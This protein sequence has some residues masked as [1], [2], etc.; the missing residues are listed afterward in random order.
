MYVER[1]LSINNGWSI[2]TTQKNEE[3]EE[4]LSALEALNDTALKKGVAAA[5]SIR[6]KDQDREHDFLSVFMHSLYCSFL[7][8]GFGWIDKLPELSETLAPI[9]GR[10]FTK[11]GLLASVVGPKSLAGKDFLTS[12][13]LNNP[14]YYH[15]GLLDIS[16]IFIPTTKSIKHLLKLKAKKIH[17]EGLV[18]EDICRTEFEKFSSLNSKVPVVLAFF[19]PTKSEE[20]AVEEVILLGTGT[21]T[22]ERTIEFAPEYYQ[23]GVGLL[24][25]FGE[26]LRQK[27]PHT[28]AKV[29]IE[30]DGNTVRLHI[31]PPVGEIEIIEKQLQQFALVIS[32]QA[33][34]ET[35][36]E[37][38]MHIMQLESR[39]EIAKLEIKNA[40]DL[41]Q[42][43]DGIYSQQI[44]SLRQQVDSLTQQVASQVLQQGK[45]VN[46]TQPDSKSEPM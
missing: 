5:R 10:L 9:Y 40:H 46:L 32:N 26:V 42:L 25:Y 15:A 14:Y 37:N 21:P 38:R 43:T 12:I 11:H 44:Q 39:L 19:S 4:A 8:E 27:D 29:R 22:I 2:L 20:I 17:I 1:V 16:V 31:V 45:I 13:Y 36:F 30:Q 28:M 23:A 3:W 6:V 33:P 7:N 34:P 24:S 41:K 18:T 35:L